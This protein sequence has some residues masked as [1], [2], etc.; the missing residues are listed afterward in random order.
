MGFDGFA[1]ITMGGGAGNGTP[2]QSVGQFLLHLQGH[3]VQREQQSSTGAV[4][5]GSGV[6]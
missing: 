4:G 6:P 1:G 3:W 5:L 2:S